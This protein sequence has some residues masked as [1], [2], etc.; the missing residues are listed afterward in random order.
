MLKCKYFI[1]FSYFLE[2]FVDLVR[3]HSHT[4]I[5]DTNNH[6]LSFPIPV[7]T[8]MLVQLTKASRT[9]LNSMV[10]VCIV[11]YSR[12]QWECHGNLLVYIMMSVLLCVFV[13]VILKSHLLPNI[14]I[15][16][17]PAKTKCC[18]CVF[19]SIFTSV[20]EDDSVIFLS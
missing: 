6:Y 16:L 8:V 1:V 14:L 19:P 12:F 15:V 9:M 2:V 5:P 11:F 13:E 20:F 10:A 3:F 18:V 17:F 7:L 4:I